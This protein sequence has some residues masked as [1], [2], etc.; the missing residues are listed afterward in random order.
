MFADVRNIVLYDLNNLAVRNYFSKDIEASTGNPN[1]QLWRYFIISQIYNFI[2]SLDRV[3]EVI[4]AVDCKRSWRKLYWE[5]YKEKRKLK[6]DTSSVDWDIYHSEFDKYIS[7]IK[8]YLP[9]KLLK[10]STAEADDIIGVICL[11]DKNNFVI[12]SGDED[13]L[14]L[15]SDN[16]KIWNPSKESYISIDSSEKFIIEKCLIGQPKDDIFNIKT[17]LDWPVDKRK[18]G[19]GK[20]SAQ[21]VMDEGYEE[22][23]KKE[24]LEERFKVNKVLIDFH[25]IPGVVKKAIIKQYR[26][27]DLPDPKNIF[28]FFKRNRFRGFIEDFDKVERKLLELYGG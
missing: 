7:E 23:L 13:Y 27:Y 10:V 12:V 26:N 18:P 6:R 4:L 25:M 22:W 9:F 5:R 24:G 28:T 15:C 8:R 20:K 19:F 2:S 14:Q 21:K 16:V 17:P 3:D 1:I 11:T